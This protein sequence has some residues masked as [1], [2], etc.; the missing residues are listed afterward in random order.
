[1][2]YSDPSEFFKYII[3]KNDI[4]VIND[5]QKCLSMALDLLDSEKPY[6]KLLKLAINNNIYKE[7]LKAY[8]SDSNAKT[9]CINKA[10]KILTDDCFIDKEKAIWAVGW[11]ATVIYSSEWIKVI[12]N[13]SSKVKKDDKRKHNDN[14]QNNNSEQEKI[15]KI[16]VLN[17]NK[18][19]NI[20]IEH[21][22][23]IFD[24]VKN[25]KFPE[26]VEELLKNGTNPN[27]ISVENNWTPLR[28]AARNNDNPEILRVLLK[29]GAN[30]NL[31]DNYGW[32]ALMYL[33]RYFDNS[34]SIKL[35]LEHGA[36]PNIKNNDGWTA[37][38]IVSRYFDN[39]ESLK[40]LLEHG[41]NPDHQTNEGW[42]A[43]MSVAFYS[44][45]LNCI[46]ILLDY[47]A[48]PNIKKNDGWTAL[49]LAKSRNSQSK[50]DLLFR[51]GADETYSYTNDNFDNDEDEVYVDNDDD[52]Y[53]DETLQNSEPII[54]AEDYNNFSSQINI[55]ENK[56][57][58]FGTDTINLE[59]VYCPAGSFIMGSPEPIQ[60]KGL[61]GFIGLT[62]GGEL[63]RNYDEKQHQ[64]IIS[65]PF[66]IGKYPVIQKQYLALMKNNPSAFNGDNNPV[67]YVSCDDTKKFL[68]ILNSKY[69]KYL[70][71]NYCFDL[72]T[73]EQWEYACR[74]GTTTALNSGKNLTSDKDYCCNL[75][76]VGW[77]DCNSHYTTHPVGQKIPNSWGIYDMHGNV[78]EWCK[79]GII[80]GGCWSRNA[81]FCRSASR[82]SF[83]PTRRG[84]FL[85]F[86]VAIVPMD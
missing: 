23:D 52:E 60:Q 39:P 21:F 28:W 29:Y 72:P 59:M 79:N 76:E 41:A 51:Y 66:M 30:P 62:E 22:S 78:W 69:K 77:Y 86:R 68:K 74:A 1:M 38:N 11:L 33:T 16:Q 80:R 25:A 64:I 32:T 71:V 36:N 42:T 49:D 7:L 54:S 2:K 58:N 8:N 70:P 40:L 84:N 50:I 46:R 5:T 37:L 73:E 20:V 27:C 57:W 3:E 10:I 61:F 35:L 19:N 18:T 63:G 26:S 56:N 6:F 53:Y 45:N 31:Q 85:G 12:D 14:K 9:L 43:L 47:N 13:Y 4:N 55:F 65:K 15:N 83:N 17:Q 48:N 75:D 67:E 81:M 44:S 34:Q 82:D 24:A